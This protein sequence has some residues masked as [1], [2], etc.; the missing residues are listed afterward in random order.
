M[1]WL[2]R[3]MVVLAVL[4]LLSGGALG[5]LAYGPRHTP[6]GQPALSATTLESFRDDFNAATGRWRVLVLLSPT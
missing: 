6:V 5:L 2:R 1:R 4:V 3:V